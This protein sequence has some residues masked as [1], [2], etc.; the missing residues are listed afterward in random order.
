MGI[1]EWFDGRLG[2]VKWSLFGIQILAAQDLSGGC[3]RQL[4]PPK[5]RKKNR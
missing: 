2:S 3:T 4:E 5:E 1:I